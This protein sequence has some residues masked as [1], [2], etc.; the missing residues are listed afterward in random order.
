LPTCGLKQI[1]SLQATLKEEQAFRLAAEERVRKLGA[2]FGSSP[3]TLN[4]ALAEGSISEQSL[5]ARRFRG[6]GL[7][8]S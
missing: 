6:C 4:T 1:K 7:D 2:G 8:E 3:V 5:P